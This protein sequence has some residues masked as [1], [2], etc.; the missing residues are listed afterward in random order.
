MLNYFI[1]P[2]TPSIELDLSI[3][4]SSTVYMAMQL[5]TSINE[6]ALK[7]TTHTKCWADAIWAR[8][9]ACLEQKMFILWR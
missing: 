4:G 5:F 6:N 7:C 3:I 9:H 8:L 2:F 1:I